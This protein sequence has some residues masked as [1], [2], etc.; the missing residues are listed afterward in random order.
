MLPLLFNSLMAS[1][2]SSVPLPEVNQAASPLAQMHDI[3]LPETVSSLPIAPGYWMVLLLIVAILSWI[4]KK[5][6]KKYRYHAPRRMAL[7][8]LNAMDSNANTFASEVNSLLKRT[9]MTYLPR[10]SLAHLNGQ[11]WFDWLD[12]RLPTHHQ[13]MIGPL[14]FK[15]H[16]QN[17]LTR[18]DNQQL[19]TLAVLWLANSSP[20]E[21]VPIS[22]TDKQ[23]MPEVQC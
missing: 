10:Q 5:G 12:K 16:Q 11:P 9:A 21:Q 22:T 3:A 19:L 23:T 18:E 20:F 2:T 6:L 14:L 8:M 7:A 1:A 13:G 15:R 17:G 4:L